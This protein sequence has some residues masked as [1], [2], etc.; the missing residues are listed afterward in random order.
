MK[1]KGNIRALLALQEYPVAV[2]VN[3]VLHLPHG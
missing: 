3:N 1:P 2:L